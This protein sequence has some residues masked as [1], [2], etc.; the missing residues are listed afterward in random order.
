ME[1]IEEHTQPSPQLGEPMDGQAATGQQ[2]TDAVGDSGSRQSNPEADLSGGGNIDK[3]RDILFGVQMRDYEKRFARL[4]ER[5]IKESNGLRDDTKKRFDSLELYLKQELESLT[6]RLTAEQNTRSESAEALSQDIKETARALEKRTAQMDE[7]T[8]RSQREL[9]QQILDQ[10]KSLNDEI[11]QKYE[12]LTAA[13]QREAL[14]LRT[15]KTDR[16]ALAALFTEVAMRLNND[17]KIP[18]AE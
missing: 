9:R 6:E 16:S 17:F 11:R 14:E 5:L 12:E 7:Q 4:E 1:R 8:A 10:S 18:G 2:H 15:D 13:L 3:I